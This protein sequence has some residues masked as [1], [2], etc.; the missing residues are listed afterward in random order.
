M[1]KCCRV[2]GWKRP[3]LSLVWPCAGTRVTLVTVVPPADVDSMEDFDWMLSKSGISKTQAGSALKPKLL[4]TSSDSSFVQC[5]RVS[6]R[7]VSLLFE[8]SRILK[9]FKQPM[10]M[11]KLFNSVLDNLSSSKWHNVLNYSKT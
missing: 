9:S 11:G 1:A 5:L 3:A 6:G 2:E 8:T 10:D 7:V 4:L